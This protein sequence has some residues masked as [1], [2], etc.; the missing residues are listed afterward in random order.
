MASQYVLSRM[1][2][3][4]FVPYLDLS[5]GAGL[6]ADRADHVT[7]VHLD[8]FLIQTEYAL[9]PGANVDVI[10]NT[11]LHMLEVHNLVPDSG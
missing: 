11:R 8:H 2:S 1:V 3:I 5:F 9:V 4:V 7:A 10:I 6:T